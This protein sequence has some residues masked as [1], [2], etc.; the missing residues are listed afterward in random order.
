MNNKIIVQEPEEMLQ[1]IP[2][3][4]NSEIEL[5]GRMTQSGNKFLYNQKLTLE[6][7]PEIQA[8]PISQVHQIHDMLLNF[9]KTLLWI[10]LHS[11]KPNT[12]PQQAQQMIQQ[13]ENFTNNPTTSVRNA[14][15]QVDTLLK[16]INN[17]GLHNPKVDPSTMML[18]YKIIYL[19]LYS[20][21]HNEKLHMTLVTKF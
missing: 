14:I 4:N 16:M 3:N 2:F 13:F 20:A 15:T 17:T 12:T 11:S 10:D 21:I 5:I 6:I 1:E 7:T 8:M 9:V 19:V 18:L